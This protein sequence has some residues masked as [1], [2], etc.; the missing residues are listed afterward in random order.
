MADYGSSSRTLVGPHASQAAFVKR[1]RGHAA[2]GI[3]SNALKAIKKGRSR[4]GHDRRRLGLHYDA[5]SVIR[6]KEL[7]AFVQGA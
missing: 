6:Y 5:D 1:R 3:V 7:L 2:A 4:W